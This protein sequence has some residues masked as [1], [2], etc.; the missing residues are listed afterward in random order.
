MNSRD[1]LINRH[2]PTTFAK[3][4][5]N[6]EEI[7]A[8]HRRIKDP[9]RPHTYL[10]TGP[11]GVGKTTLARIIGSALDCDIEEIPA[12][13]HN[14][15]ADMRELIEGFHYLLPGARARLIILDE[16]HR[17][18]APAWD[19]AL[20]M[21]EEPPSHIYWA[22]CTTDSK[23]PVTV[24]T[25]SHRIDL[26]PLSEQEIVGLLIEVLDAEGWTNTIDDGIVQLI[27][28]GCGGSPRQA[29]NLLEKAHDAP[30]LKEAQRIIALQG[31]PEP[32]I[33]ALQILISGQGKWDAVRPMLAQ[34]NDNE[35]TES[36]LIHAARYV[37]GA[38]SREESDKRAARQ[39][40]SWRRS[41]TPFTRMTPNQCSTRQ[42]AGCYGAQSDARHPRTRQRQR[43]PAP[44][45]HA[46]TV[47]RPRFLEIDRAYMETGKILQQAG[48]L[49]AEADAQE[50][51]AKHTL[52]IIKAEA[53]ERLRA[54][55]V[56][57][58]D[59]SEARIASLLPMEQDVQD[60]REAFDRSHYEAQVCE[61]LYKSLADQSRLLTKASDMI[62]GGYI[63][64]SAAYE[65]R[66]NEIRRA[67]V[68]ADREGQE[69]IGRPTD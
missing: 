18:T 53:S 37:M 6:G 51:A 40:G 23:L 29:L 58:K 9:R 22:L 50:S 68:A 27:V 11:S 19:A 65:D 34:I 43:N 16:C 63:S 60:A 38:M 45:L 12:A 44:L 10:F 56:G 17:L 14:G 67:R 33:Q 54:I 46:S 59:P 39:W 15:V 48:E 4:Y 28:Q 5:G 57:G 41:S 13:D 55:P 30:S 35:F 36:S 3:V 2:R 20:K 32:M 7:D 64:P 61:T 21:L 62:M 26:K 49:A 66:R 1:E 8:L 47:P 31:S 69:R 52:D 24:L 42:L 25:R